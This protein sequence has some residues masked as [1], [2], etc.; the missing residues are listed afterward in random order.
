MASDV[1]ILIVMDVFT[2]FVIRYII[3]DYQVFFMLGCPI[4]LIQRSKAIRNLVRKTIH[5]DEFVRKNHT[6]DENCLESVCGRQSQGMGL[7]MSREFWSVDGS[8]FGRRPR[9]QARDSGKNSRR[10]KASE[11]VCQVF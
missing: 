11:S 2:K 8:F 4:V 1:H 5:P 9:S 3:P 7:P 6:N 10:D